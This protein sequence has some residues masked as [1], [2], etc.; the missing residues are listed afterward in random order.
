MER[1]SHLKR[2]EKLCPKREHQDRWK[3][4]LVRKE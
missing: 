1:R 3:G 4:E 2:V